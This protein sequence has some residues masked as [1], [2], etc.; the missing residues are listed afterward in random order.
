MQHRTQADPATNAATPRG[1]FASLRGKLR[2]LSASGLGL[3]VASAIGLI[4]SNC[5]AAP[6]YVQMISYRLGAGAVRMPVQGWVNDG[7]MSVFFLLVGLEIRRELTQGRLATLRG[8]AGPGIAA[9]GGMAMPAAIFLALNHA[10]PAASRGWAVPMATDIAF[11]L[12]VLRF[13]GRRAAAPLRVFLTAVAI[14]DDLGAI[15]VIALF[16]TQAVW[17]PALGVA[18]LVWLGLLALRRAGMRAMW[19]YMLGGVAMWVCLMQSGVQPSLAGVALAFAVPPGTRLDHA[20]EPVVGLVILPIFG[21]MNAGLD[22]RALDFSTLGTAAPLGVLLGLCV[23]K[24]VGVFGAAILGRALG[25][26]T[27]PAEMSLRDLYGAALLCGIGFTMSL[28]I[29]NLAFPP[30]PALNGVKLAVLCASVLSAVL[31]AGF[32]GLVPGRP[33]NPGA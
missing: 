21:L 3:I 25:L 4:W 1:R 8:M 30:G 20:L 19:P 23:G 32:L 33:A 28:F 17:L 14:L 5:A 22:L 13:L 2:R 31:G 27:L 6:L 9:L 29:G 24:Q 7:L 11:S 10:D 12:V 18:C 15:A 26:L 16:Y